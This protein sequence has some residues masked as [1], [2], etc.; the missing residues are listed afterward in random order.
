MFKHNSLKRTALSIVAGIALMGLAAC[1]N[2]SG[3]PLFGANGQPS[4]SAPTL[5]PM[6]SMTMDLSFFGID[7]TSIAQAE[8]M[9]AEM[10]L[11]GA[12]DRSNWIAAI[13]RV[14]YIQLTL[15]DILE[16][17]V[18][19]FA[20]AIHSVP[21]AQPDG[22][23]LWT[24]I[25]VEDGNEYSIFLYGKEEGDHVAWR[26]EVSTNVP[27]FMLDHFV[28]FEGESKVDESGGYW[29]FYKPLLSGGEALASMGA[30]TD[31]APVVRMD[32]QN[33]GNAEEQ[34]TIL[35]NEVGGEDEGDMLVFHATPSRGTI[36]YH[37]A[38]VLEDH[39]ITWHADGSGSLAVGDYNNGEQSCWDTNQK[40]TDCP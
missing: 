24:F 18:G 35:V 26:L 39:N 31:G 6:S 22:S 29:Q 10:M 14:L 11:A 30:A 25:F 7:G 33:Y 21:Q 16:E 8:A 19:A 2:E 38:D 15:F 32:W 13:V 17:P 9:N 12:G 34:L 27:G 3:E 1:S 40:D 4:S 5:P 36:D 23:Y 20:A 37:D 28:W